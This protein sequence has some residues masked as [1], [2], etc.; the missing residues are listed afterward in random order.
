[1]QF[2]IVPELGSIYVGMLIIKEQEKKHEQLI[3]FQNSGIFM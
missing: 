3:I 2:N 1:M